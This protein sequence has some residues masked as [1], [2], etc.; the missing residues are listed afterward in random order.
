MSDNF[1]RRHYLNNA[2]RTHRIHTH[3]HAIMTEFHD[4]KEI[5]DSLKTI[6]AWKTMETVN[7]D[8]FPRRFMENVIKEGWGWNV[9]IEELTGE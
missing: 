9:V 3:Q 6:G 1:T 4:L 5:I 2:S 8:V 7:V